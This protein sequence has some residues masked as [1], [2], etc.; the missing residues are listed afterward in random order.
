M[1]TRILSA[2]TAL[3]AATL[4]TPVLA[5]YDG[6]TPADGHQKAVEVEGIAEYRIADAIAQLNDE[7]V[8]HSRTGI[9]YAATNYGDRT[10]DFGEGLYGLTSEPGFVA[11]F[12]ML[13]YFQE[14]EEEDE[15]DCRGKGL[16]FARCVKDRMDKGEKCSS[17][18]EGD[19]Y[20]AYCE[21]RKD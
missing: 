15:P 6:G 13:A 4:M 10:H 21:P 9:P 18:K 16:K 20:V 1:R 17:W 3:V 8:L 14:E 7:Q 5:C 11:S 2:A 19:E 12:A